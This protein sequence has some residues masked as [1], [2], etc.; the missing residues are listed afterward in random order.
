MRNSIFMQMKLKLLVLLVLCLIISGCVDS[1]KNPKTA[2]LPTPAS[3]RIPDPYYCEVDPWL[4][5]SVFGVENLIGSGVLRRYDPDNFDCS[6]MAAYI[7]WMLEKH[8]FDAKICLSKSFADTEMPHAWVAVDIAPRRYYIE[9]TARNQGGFSYSV[10]KP[11]DG[12][13]EDYDRYD[14]IYEDIYELSNAGSISEF[15]WW[16]DPGLSHNFEEAH[17]ER[18]N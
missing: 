8:G 14:G 4:D 1:P 15:D 10:I 5:H 18:G 9:P 7:E 16:S 11:L 12:N 2:S 3:G 6:E 13:Y 17:S